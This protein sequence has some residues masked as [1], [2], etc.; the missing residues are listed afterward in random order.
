MA[1]EHELTVTLEH[2]TGLEFKVLF[3]STE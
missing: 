3:A 2:L 1:G